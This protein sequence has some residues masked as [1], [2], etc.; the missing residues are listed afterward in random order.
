MDVT[1]FEA[2]G[3]LMAIVYEPNKSRVVRWQ[4]PFVGKPCPSIQ[5]IF[6][7]TEDGLTVIVL[8]DGLGTR[9]GYLVRF[10]DPAMVMYYEETNAPID[11]EWVAAGGHAIPPS[12]SYKWEHSPLLERNRLLGTEAWI[13]GA[14]LEHYVIAGGDYIIEVLAPNEPDI[15]RFDGPLTIHQTYDL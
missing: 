4:T 7:S 5:P 10:S 15:N 9:P 6:D 12:A 3:S 11:P 14:T 8:P 1:G 2:A 13:R